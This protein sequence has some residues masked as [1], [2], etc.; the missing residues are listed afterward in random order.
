MSAQDIIMIKGIKGKTIILGLAISLIA[1][2]FGCATVPK[3]ERQ[4]MQ[5]KA[6]KQTQEEFSTYE[7]KNFMVSY[8]SG[9]EIPILT[10]IFQVR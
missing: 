6:E 7:G 2:L 3:T 10:R 1:N 9:W 8:P 5:V 4:L